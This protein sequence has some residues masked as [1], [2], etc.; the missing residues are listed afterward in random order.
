MA[1]IRSMEDALA[2]LERQVD[3]AQASAGQ[4]QRGLKLLGRASKDG[5][6]SAIRKLLDDQSDL[7][8]AVRSDVEG[9]KEA[10]RYSQEEERAFLDSGRYIAE[11]SDVAAQQRVSAVQQDGAL[12][13]YPVVVRV[14]AP[15]R[16]V[17]VDRKLV[18]AIRP[19]AVVSRLSLLQRKPVRGKPA[20]FLEA[21]YR[22]WQYARHRD[23][24]GKLLP[25][26]VRVNELYDVFTVAPGSGA[27]YS[28]Q[29]FG[30]DLYLL[31]RSDVRVTRNGQRLRFS[32][33]TGAKD[34]A[35]SIVV[36]GEDGQQITYSSVSFAND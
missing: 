3:R 24:Q 22:A 25:S 26:D 19:T 23:S 28:R 11:L 5:D 15:R 13:C 21:L 4:L 17:T 33:S 14:D 6:L 34:R 12:L 27:E 10:W 30:R 2:S 20:L 35:A 18:R 29:E 32:R 16:A 8:Q 9:L 1:D 36:V 31:E 7:N